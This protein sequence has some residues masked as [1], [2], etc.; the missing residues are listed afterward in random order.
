LD[1]AE[2]LLLLASPQAANSP[3]VAREVEYFLR[4][5]RPENILILLT[6]GD[7]DSSL[8]QSLRTV[9]VER[10]PLFVDLR[11]AINIDGKVQ[12]DPRFQDAVSRIVAATSGLELREVRYHEKR[13]KIR[14]RVLVAALSAALLAA[15]GL[16]VFKSERLTLRSSGPPSAAAE[17]KR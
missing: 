3:W 17:L 10:Q 11:W 2:H 1:S 4:N 5:R 7:L 6:G 8:P 12:R 16:V 14:R 13:R 9:A 15:A